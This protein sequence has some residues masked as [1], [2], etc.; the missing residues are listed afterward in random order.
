MELF[1]EARAAITAYDV[2]RARAAELS[3]ELL[4]ANRAINV[5]KEQ[6]AAG[7]VTARQADLVRLQATKA[8]QEPTVASLCDAYSGEKA[9]KTAT[10][11]QRDQARQR[12]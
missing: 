5:I 1:P 9:A 7:N 12:P 3:G 2:H 10:E 6:A 4:A 11:Q 8:R